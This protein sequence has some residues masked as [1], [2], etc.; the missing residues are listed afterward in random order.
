VHPRSKTL[1]EKQLRTLLK[2]AYAGDPQARTLLV[3]M[4]LPFAR[5]MAKKFAHGRTDLAEDLA[6]DGVLGFLD[7]LERCN[8]A[9]KPDFMAYAG[10]YMVSQIRRHALLDA[11]PVTGAISANGNARSTMRAFHAALAEG[12]SRAQAI[13]AA[14]KATG[15]SEDNA[16]ARIEQNYQTFGTV[17]FEQPRRA[18]A[19]SVADT[20]ADGGKPLD[21]LV[22]D[23]ETRTKVRRVLDALHLSDADRILVQ[24]RFMDDASLKEIGDRLGVSRED[25]RQREMALL[26]KLRE[27]LAIEFGMPI[28]PEQEQP[29]T[30]PDDSDVDGDKQDENLSVLVAMRFGVQDRKDLEHLAG[31]EALTAATWVRREIRIH[32]RRLSAS[33]HKTHDRSAAVSRLSAAHRAPGGPKLTALF[34]VRMSP[35]DRKRLDRLA[36]LAGVNVS[37]WVRQKIQE[38]MTSRSLPAGRAAN[39]RAA[40]R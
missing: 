38:R 40:A 34:A 18:D 32:D 4:A 31:L 3:G 1:S 6:S 36:E 9:K 35:E 16:R 14:A 13:A 25:I 8:P 27:R 28:A 5:R 10:R 12:L 17:S 37:E 23:K 2:R 19:L 29:T 33:S 15:R 11:S 30:L 22:A 26:P 20:M 7:A 39:D 24:F 21:D